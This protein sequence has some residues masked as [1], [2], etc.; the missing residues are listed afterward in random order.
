MSFEKFLTQFS[1]EP[2]IFRTDF[3][4]KIIKRKVCSFLDK[5]IITDKAAPPEEQ[6]HNRL[7]ERYCATVVLRLHILM[8][9][10][11]HHKKYWWFSIRRACDVSNLLSTKRLKGVITNPCDL[12]HCEK[13]EYCSLVNMFAP[14]YINYARQEGELKNKWKNKSLTCI[15]IGNCTYTDSLQFLTPC[16][17]K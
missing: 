9:A 2:K 10:E 12:V 7:A 11:L 6:N 1:V 17:N 16:V 8:Q 3:D 15:L 14:A 4:R 13:V 5:E